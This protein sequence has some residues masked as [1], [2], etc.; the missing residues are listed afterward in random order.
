VGA[1]LAAIGLFVKIAED[2][3]TREST[4]FD[5]TVS[6]AVHRLADPSLDRVM[7]G[8]S[9]IG[10]AAV[11]L[12]TV[13]LM[14]AWAVK[15]KDSRAAAT[16]IAVAVT[17]E[18]LNTILKAAFQRARPSLWTVAVLHSYSFPSGH[19]MAAVAIYGMAAPTARPHR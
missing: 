14:V 17:T 4:L 3:V 6:V 13:A 9:T 7:Q 19:A 10:S 15:R 1:N 8:F 5:R 12:P 16:L 2:V 18:G 11:V